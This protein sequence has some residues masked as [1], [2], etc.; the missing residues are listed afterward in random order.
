MGLSATPEATPRH[1]RSTAPAAATR[2]ADGGL[3]ITSSPSRRPVRRAAT[4]PTRVRV[5]AFLVAVSVVALTLLLTVEARHER[6]GLEVIGDQTAP[7][8]V[9]STDL[10]FALND[11]DAQLANI[12][13]VGNETNLGF[14]RAQALTIYQQRR[15]QV[16]QDLQRAAAAADADPAAA[17][18]IRDILDG[19]GR[20]ETLAAQMLLL[21][22]Q[23]SHS[24]G[25]PSPATVTTY[26]RATDLLK[27][28]LLPA[29]QDLA[30]RNAQTLEFTY[31]SQR[32]RALAA[33]DWIVLIGVAMLAAAIVLQVY[34][35]RRFHRWLNPALAVA[36][37]TAAAVAVS[38]IVLT[39]KGAEYLRVAKKDAFD[40][41]LVLDQARA[42]SYDANA[43][44][45]RYLVD[46]SRSAKYE[47]AF[48]AKTT[49]LVDLS[50]ATLSTFD[51]RLDV[52]L[53][54]YRQDNTSIEWQGFYGKEFRN[55]TFTGERAAAETALQRY[56]T[57][58]LDDR[59]IRRLAE[60]GRL[61][62]A[63]AFCTSYNPGDSN[64]AFDQYDKA[65]AAVIS[66]N[67][68]AFDQSISD[69]KRQLT[70]W[71]VIP[72][73]AGLIVLG[74]LLL[75]LRVRLAEYH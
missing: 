16:S 49:Q 65:L 7:V 2:T 58:Q 44:E 71:T 51:Q 27:A 57:Y 61:R 32:N 70:G 50:G 1:R 46:P 5:L 41:I 6:G 36:T 55:I 29:A 8:V 67:Q 18:S 42:V 10:Y 72:A 74:L 66:I 17:Q 26:R 12:L 13:L 73:A 9:A 14:T 22:Q 21:D 63:I 53:R 45:S 64:Y 24:A 11:M 28:T 38:G 48:L 39:T 4:T 43:D 25:K 52:A 62:D 47:Q 69:G 3:R 54:A 68:S 15:Q 19:L 23:N 30:D 75:G 35:A 56:Q 34:V 20:Y 31:Q 33:R 40:S 37:L 59:R 60:A